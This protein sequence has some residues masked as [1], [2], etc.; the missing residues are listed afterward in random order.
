MKW[1]LIVLIIGASGF[2]DPIVPSSVT[3]E[4]D[5]RD[6]C[7]AAKQYY[8]SEGFKRRM[9]QNSGKAFINLDVQCHQKD[10]LPLPGKVQK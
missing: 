6:L 1:T 2:P 3:A 8:E 10:Y 4:F 9:L 7:V 5:S